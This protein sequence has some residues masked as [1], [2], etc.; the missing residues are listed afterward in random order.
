MK[1]ELELTGI[2][3][4]YGGLV[5]VDDVTLTVPVGRVT[6][7]VGPNGAGKSTLFSLVCGQQRPDT[8]TVVWRGG[9][10]TRSGPERRARVGVTRTFQTSRLI[11]GLSVLENVMVGA[12]VRGRT[13]LLE[14][15]L[16]SP[17]RRREDQA[18]RAWAMEC[19]DLVGVAD[20]A[21]Q[22]SDSLAY[23]HR[24]LVEIARALAPD[25]SM[26]LLDEPAAG[27]HTHEADR[28]GELLVDLAERGIGVLLVEHNMGLVMRISASVAVL[29]FGRLIAHGTPEQVAADPA[30]RAAY[31]GASTSEETPRA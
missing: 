30:V 20:R 7:L 21:E 29:D 19:L 13:S 3:K 18:F 15:F 24:R 26:L 2:S 1:D 9:D 6:S 23:G 5:A 22:S 14:D 27:L 16:G 11:P 25:P 17:R 12:H 8:G 4:H 31:L 28:L 10:L